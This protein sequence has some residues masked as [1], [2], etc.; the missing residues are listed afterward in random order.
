[1]KFAIC[2]ETY[3][4]LPFEAVVADVAA[5]GY[6]GIELALST[7]DPDP[8]HINDSGA[9]RIGEEV[10][11]AGLEVVGLHWLLAAP[12]RMHLT[13]ADDAVRQETVAYLQHLA[14][15]CAAMGGELLVLGSP[16]Q[17]DVPEGGN[18][19]AAFARAVDGC[20]RVA[21]T[22]GELGVTL[23]IEPL[24]PEYT[25]FITTA[26]EALRLIE[27]VD[28]PAC[29]LHLDVFAMSTESRAIPEIIHACESELVHVHA[30]DPNLGGP[31]SGDLD[32]RPIFAALHDIGYEGYVSVEV[33]DYEPDGST[34]AKTSLDYMRRCIG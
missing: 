2:N 18:Y 23:A 6:D 14:R 7:F 17:R 1:M 3:R 11:R 4:D 29:R 22:A 15:L 27:A 34:I 9:Q 31:G 13:T 20:H 24:A 16:R 10:A 12:E 26:E 8:R 33:F 32:Y 19:D 28:H 21:E 25:N 30:N 5:C